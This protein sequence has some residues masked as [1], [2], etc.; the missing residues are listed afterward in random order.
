MMDYGTHI[1][2]LICIYTILATSLDLVAGHLGLLS[3]AHAAFYGLG[4]YSSAILTT[5][6]HM[7][8]AIGL[9][10][11][12]AVSASSSL[13]ISL[14]AIRLRDDYFVMATF[15][16]QMIVFSFFNNVM[17]V[18]RGPLGI[19]NIPQARFFGLTVQ[20]G[21]GYLLLSISCT[22]LTCMVV[23]RITRGP[24]GRVLRAIREDETLAR[25]LGK[26]VDSFKVVSC[27]ISAAIAGAAGVLYAHYVAYIDPSTFTIADS[28]FILSIVIIG[29]SASVWGA[30]TGA[31]AM[32]ILPEALRFL[33]LPSSIAANVRQI[34]YGTLL[35]LMMF[36]R[37][38]G[39]MG[40]FNVGR[41]RIE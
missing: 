8:F 11:G 7:P 16:F 36:G 5:Y 14:P 17:A 37:P 20:S 30:A 29:G 26:R 35:V 31:A 25:A 15:G 32:V 23:D 28:I 41:R 24:Y 18:T 3:V 4:A 38:Q 9:L 13:S 40:T 39:L 34:V 33:G 1:C 12:M 27:A 22:C 10:V 21:T 6:A 2:I 19:T